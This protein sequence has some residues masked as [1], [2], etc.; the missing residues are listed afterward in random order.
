MIIFEIL[1]TSRHV[2]ALMCNISHCLE[3]NFFG[4]RPVW[5]PPFLGRN[6]R[7]S[8]PSKT[9]ACLRLFGQG[10]RE[11]VSN[12]QA[13]RWFFFCGRY[14]NSTSRR[15]VMLLVL[16]VQWVY[17]RAKRFHP[18]L[19]VTAARASLVFSTQSCLCGALHCIKHFPHTRFSCRDPLFQRCFSTFLEWVCDWQSSLERT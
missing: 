15:G 11:G 12:L 2:S 13:S 4:G 17:Q 16:Q 19:L 7:A 1:K 5:Y 9:W 6:L 18:L 14:V 10:N 3:T 8:P